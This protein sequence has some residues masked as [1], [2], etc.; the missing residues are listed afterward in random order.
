MSKAKA[1][2]KHGW[3]DLADGLQV[4]RRT[5]YSWRKLPGAPRGAELKPWKAFVAKRNL[6]VAPNRLTDERAELL[7]QRAEREVRLL[8]L[9]IARLESV[10]MP[11]QEVSDLLRHLVTFTRATLDPRLGRELGA[12]CAGKSPEELAI[13]GPVI[14]DEV[15]ALL[16]EGV[17]KWSQGHNVST[18]TGAPPLPRPERGGTSHQMATPAS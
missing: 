12:R 6:G 14:A 7:R 3:A 15:C 16:A 11:I 8:G 5:V 10:A 18:E 13:L 17:T 1:H 2:T 9:K 4:A